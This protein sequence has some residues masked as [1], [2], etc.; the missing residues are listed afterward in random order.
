MPKKK[1]YM[2][3]YSLFGVWTS[4][5]NNLSGNPSTAKTCYKNTGNLLDADKIVVL[6]T[7]AKT[8]KY[9][10]MSC[11]RIYEKLPLPRWIVN[12]SKVLMLLHECN[13]KIFQPLNIWES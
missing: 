8:M 4:L 7:D 13:S 1:R 10:F 3:L 12:N 9:M 2:I 6:K 11:G 5:E